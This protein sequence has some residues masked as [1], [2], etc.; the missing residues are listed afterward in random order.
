MFMYVHNNHCHRVTA[1]LQLN[2]IIIINSSSSSSSSSS[3]ITICSQTMYDFILAYF[4]H[5]SA[6]ILH[7]P[8]AHET[9][10]HEFPY[11]SPL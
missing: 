8:V 3:I 11:V 10:L 5:C 6:S 9:S 7:L 4:S 2:I 1:H